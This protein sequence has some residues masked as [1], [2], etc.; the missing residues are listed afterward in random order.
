MVW[1]LPFLYEKI[2]SILISIGVFLLFLLFRKVFA[3]YIYTLLIKLSSKAPSGFFSTFFVAF[4][5]PIQWCF[6]I[7]GAY[8]AARYFPYLEQSNT[9]F[10]NIIRS[11]VIFL[12]C[13]GLYNL[14]SS[15]TL[16]IAK[17]NEKYSFKIDKILIPLLSK[18]LRFIIVAIGFSIIAQEFGY[19]ISG[20]VAGLGLGG[21]AFSL[22][23]KDALANLFG[24][25]VIIIEKPFSVGDWILTPSAEGTVEDISF[26]STKIRTFAQALVTVPNAMLANEPITNWSEM[27]KRRVT[28]QLKVTHDTSKEKLANVIEKIESMLVLHPDIHQETIFVTFDRYGE[29]GLEIFLYFFTK[30]TAWGEYLKIKEQINY[31]ILGILENEEVLIALPARRLHFYSETDDYNNNARV[32]VRQEM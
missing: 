6:V 27:G 11:S 7:I 21:L 8:V 4:E 14:S 2:I 10:L 13:W 19:E 26:R 9:L 15:S 31:E 28:F 12:I 22:A 32:P 18:V 1:D 25:I 3:K 16:L 20:L 5:K 17:M 24:G 29:N 23:A 30:T